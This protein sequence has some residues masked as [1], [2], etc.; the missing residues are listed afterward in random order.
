M[1]LFLFHRYN[2]ENILDCFFF[3]FVSSLLPVKSISPICFFLF[4]SVSHTGHLLRLLD[5][6]GCLFIMKTRDSGKQTGRPSECGEHVDSQ[7]SWWLMG[8]LWCQCH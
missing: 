8:T 2:F 7:L 5:T 6:P 3:C 4:E 1:F